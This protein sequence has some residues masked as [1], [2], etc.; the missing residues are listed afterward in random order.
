M[1][2][3]IF[4]THK[5]YLQDFI[6]HRASEFISDAGVEIRNNRP[7][8]ITGETEEQL[9][10]DLNRFIQEIQ[11]QHAGA[12]IYAIQKDPDGHRSVLFSE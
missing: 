10:I 4:D 9:K 8:L 7:H 5:F 6:K 12:I 11:T 2:E 3:I 1:S